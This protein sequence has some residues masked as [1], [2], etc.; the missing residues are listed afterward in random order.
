[1]SF[2]YVVDVLMLGV[3]CCFVTIQSDSDVGDRLVKALVCGV[4]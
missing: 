4:L 3:T 2:W 1:M